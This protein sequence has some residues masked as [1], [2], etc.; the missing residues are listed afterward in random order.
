MNNYNSKLKRY[1]L[2]EVSLRHFIVTPNKTF[3]GH[4]QVSNRV[5]R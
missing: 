4:C 2:D 3:E 1:C 5:V